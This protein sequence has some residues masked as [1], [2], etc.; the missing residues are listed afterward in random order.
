VTPHAG[1]LL[2]ALLD[3]QLDAA[4]AA[5]VR[6]H[7][8]GCELCAQ[9]LDDVRHARRAVRELPAVEPPDWFIAELL[10]GDDVVP[11]GRHR[12][13]RASALVNIGASVAAGILLLVVSSSQL[14]PRSVSPEVD[15]A[16]ER[17]ASTVSALLGST[18]SER[19]LPPHDVPPTTAPERDASHLPAPYAAPA[20]LAGYDLVHAYRS[21]GGVHLLYER[22]HYGLSV[23]ELQGSVD[24]GALPDGGTRLSLAGHRAWRMDDDP[25]DG[26]LV[27]FEDDGMVVIVVGDEPGEAVV[28]AAAELPSARDLPLPTRLRRAMARAFESFSPAP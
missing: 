23:F 7:V 28:D 2:S 12:S 8:A 14:G 21:P 24:W 11:I 20:S 1:D 18:G 5:E 17:H 27:V 4:T 25:A 9:E 10:A 26:R 13:R 6:E 15:G 19:L 22:D 3:G 16:V